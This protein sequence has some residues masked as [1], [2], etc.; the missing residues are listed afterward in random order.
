[1]LE[2]GESRRNGLFRLLGAVY[3][4]ELAGIRVVFADDRADR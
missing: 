3:E 2:S 4:K 1:M